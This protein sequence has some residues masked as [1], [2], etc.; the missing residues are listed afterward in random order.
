VRGR[1]LLSGVALAV[2]VML[3]CLV[4]AGFAVASA[5]REAQVVELQQEATDAAAASGAAALS[6]PSSDAEDDPLR[7]AK[8]RGAE[9]HTYARYDPSGRRTAGDG[10]AVLETSLQ[11][12]LHGQSRAGR[13][14]GLRVVA[15]PLVGGGALRAAEPA[16]EADARVRAA[17]V[18]LM[19]IALGLL[20]VVVLAA[21]MLAARLVRPL[22]QVQTAASRLGGGDFST[23]APATGVREVDEV[24]EALN[25]TARRLGRLV[26]REQRLTADLAHQLRTPLTGLR[27]SL[28]GE[29]AIPRTD[30]RAVLLEALGAVDRLERTVTELTDLA[31]DELP[32]LPFDLAPAVAEAAARW[33]DAFARAGRQVRADALVEAATIARRPAVDAILDVLLENALRHGS[34][35]VTVQTEA[36]FG[37]VDV[38]IADEGRC[39]VPEAQL[40]VRRASAG[41]STGIGLHLAR[42]LAES[43]GAR[44]RLT[45]RAPTTFQLQLPTAT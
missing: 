42:T 41:G 6:I 5:E 27:V 20:I 14:Q 43:E 11:P 30:H 35:R 34:G 7:D 9:E 36:G 23:T 31:R 15:V 2:A 4:P 24:V 16:D 25:T 17:V 8:R 19:L 28:E 44:L 3:A 38:R 40:F 10:P 37:Y 33:G 22:R 13:L 45:Q 12:A 29:L 18:R 21:R 26:E 39:D 32:A 1:L